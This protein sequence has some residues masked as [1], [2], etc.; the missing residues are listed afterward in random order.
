M[1]T[2][3]AVMGKRYNMVEATA[4]GIREFLAKPVSLRDIAETVRK[5]L[6]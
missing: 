3:R 6:D 1:T 2:L 4:A 5:T